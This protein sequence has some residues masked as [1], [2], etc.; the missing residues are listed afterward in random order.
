MDKIVVLATG[1]TIAGT[2][3]G[4]AY[5]SGQVGIE[6][7]LEGVVP[8]GLRIESEQVANVGSQD[9]DSSIWLKL[10]ERIHTLSAQEDIKGFVITHGTDTME[11]T[12]YFLHL[13]L[14]S[15]KPVVLTGAM[16]NSTSLSPDGPMNLCNALAVCAHPESAG[17][18]VLVAM[19]EGIYSARGV[20][21]AHTSHLGAFKAPSGGAIG[22]VYY[23]QARFDAKPTKKHTLQSCLALSDHSQP[24]PKVAIVYTYVDCGDFLLKAALQAGVQGVVVAG[25]GNGNVSH[26]LLETMAQA[27]RQGVVVVRSSRVG[28][29]C[30]QLGEIEDARYNFVRA[31]DLNPQKARILLQLALLKSTQPQ[32]IQEFFDTH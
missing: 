27:T 14:Q 15:H 29:G 23:G 8:E 21:K 30:V 31:R 3:E 9:M 25:M 28:S 16:R 19:D 17:L 20:S 5:V 4:G 2:G 6:R 13:T 22:H 11:E 12:A 26:T 24:L 10:L 18:G 32:A 1:G 7:L